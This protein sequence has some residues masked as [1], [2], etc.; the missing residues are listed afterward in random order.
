M[1]VMYMIHRKRVVFPCTLRRRNDRY[2]LYQAGQRLRE[3]QQ[4]L[5]LTLKEV[6]EQSRR[7]AE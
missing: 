5:G 4:K 2:D 3:I 7:I 6:E 1:N